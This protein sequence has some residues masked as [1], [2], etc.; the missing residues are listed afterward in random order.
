MTGSY[1]MDI[2]VPPNAI[3]LHEEDEWAGKGLM[4]DV[5]L[6]DPMAISHA[7][8][9]SHQQGFVAAKREQE[10][11][12][13]YQPELKDPRKPPVFD[14]DT[15]VLVPFTIE[16]YGAIGL[17]GQALLQKL[18]CHCA[19]GP[20]E[21]D[22]VAYNLTLRMMRVRLAVA[23][24]KLLHERST[25]HREQAANAPPPRTIRR[26]ATLQG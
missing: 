3:H 25:Y 12:D 24:Q 7:R 9:A 20:L 6:G 22:L 16:M 15:R 11:R 23:L 18:A 2:T 13:H 21:F 10:K 8:Q 5:S 4:I 14:S 26:S 19:G 17:S 1:E